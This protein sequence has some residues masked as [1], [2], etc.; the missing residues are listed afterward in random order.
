MVVNTIRQVKMTVKSSETDFQQQLKLSNLFLW[1]QDAASDHAASLGFGYDDLMQQELAWVLSRIK[2]RF[3][4]FPR[5]GE[6]VTLET[7]PKGIQQKVFFMRDYRLTGEDGRLLTAATSAY[8]V[9]NTL[10]RRMALPNAL[11]VQVPDNGGM[12]AIDE[13]LERIMPVEKL[14]ECNTVHTGYSMVDIMGHVNNAR[15]IDW[16]SDCFSIEEY[17]SRHCGWLQIN[18]LNEVKPGET[19]RLL[20]GEHL[21]KQ[22]VVYIAGANQTTGARAFEAEMGWE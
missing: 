17:Q 21:D 1:L 16:V 12:S 6:S 18:F 9:I 19:V 13:P 7:W 20:R 22:N 8:L 11:D 15:Y 14:R 10:N 3:F 4:D 2:A 5:M